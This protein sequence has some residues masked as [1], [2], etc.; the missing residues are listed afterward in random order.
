M[1]FLLES[2]Y[3]SMT[4]P[5]AGSSKYV[6]ALSQWSSLNPPL[7]WDDAASTRE[8]EWGYLSFLAGLRLG[9]ETGQAFS[10]MWMNLS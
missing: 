7:D 5:L 3:E 2:L 4:R 6:E 10:G 9:L 1:E 8:Y